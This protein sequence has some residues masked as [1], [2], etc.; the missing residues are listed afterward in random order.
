MLSNS[1]FLVDILDNLAGGIDNTQIRI[2]AETNHVGV[3]TQKDKTCGYW[4]III[5]L[6]VAI[7]VIGLI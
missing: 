3:V 1:I 2:E 4:I 7:C 6:F 5:S